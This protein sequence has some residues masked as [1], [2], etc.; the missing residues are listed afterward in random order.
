[1]ASAGSL[2]HVQDAIDAL[3]REG[4]IFLLVVGRPGENYSRTF[5]K[6]RGNVGAETKAELRAVVEEHLAR[7]WDEDDDADTPPD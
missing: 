1:V 5:S 3:N 6:N 2:D 4:V 7:W